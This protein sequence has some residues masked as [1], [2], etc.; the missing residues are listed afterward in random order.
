MAL[1]VLW[2]GAGLQVGNLVVVV[3][4]ALDHGWWH[5]VLVVAGLALAGQSHQCYVEG[6]HFHV[7]GGSVGLASQVLHKGEVHL[8]VHLLPALL[9]TAFLVQFHPV[10]HGLPC[11]VAQG[12]E[13]STAVSSC[14]G[15]GPIG[16]FW[17]TLAV[18]QHVAISAVQVVDIG[19]LWVFRIA[20][21]PGI[22]I[23]L[24]CQQQVAVEGLQYQV[25][26][27]AVQTGGE[28]HTV[29]FG[30]SGEVVGSH[31]CKR[32]CAVVGCRHAVG[33]E[34]IDV[35]LCPAQQVSGG[36]A[37][38]IP[39]VQSVVEQDEIGCNLPHAGH[40]AVKGT[41][42]LRPQ[43]AAYRIHLEQPETVVPHQ[44]H[45]HLLPFVRFLF[46]G[47]EA[48]RAAP[49][50]E[51]NAHVGRF[52]AQGRKALWKLFAETVRTGGTVHLGSVHRPGIKGV[53]V[54]LHPVCVLQ[55]AEKVQIDARLGIRGSFVRIVDP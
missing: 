8:H 7:Y 35:G 21:Q 22:G 17:Q 18:H 43:L 51:V 29:V 48:V 53:D 1:C 34:H 46:G 12:Q 32:L 15:S 47:A 28:A 55:P 33:H 6:Q 54:D 41:I 37:C 36:V 40:H 38:G 24:G 5:D 3:G 27:P 52:L 23:N 2:H 50:A 42:F 13:L 19:Q 11:E 10:G 9:Q 4:L 20:Q 14:D 25:V 49:Q 45:H 26:L 16:L 30:Q 44:S 31:A 39:Q